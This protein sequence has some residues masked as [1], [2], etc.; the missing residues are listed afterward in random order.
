MLDKAEARLSKGDTTPSTL[1]EVRS[2]L[3]EMAFENYKKL[4]EFNPDDRQFRWEYGKIARV[5]GNLK[6]TVR[7]IETANE[8]IRLSLELQNWTPTNQRTA[9]ESDY[10]AETYRELA[11]NLITAGKLSD[12]KEAIIRSIEIV[13]NLRTSFPENVNYSRTLA[14]AWLEQVEIE[15]N[16]HQFEKASELAALAF[17]ELSKLAASE[18][19]H[20]LD[21]LMELFSRCHQVEILLRSSKHSEAST[22]AKETLSLVRKKL[23][24]QPN[25]Q[26]LPQSLVAILLIASEI[27]LMTDGNLVAV[28]AWTDE[29]VQTIAT[30]K[31]SMRSASL[32]QDEARAFCLQAEALRKQTKLT[33]AAVAIQSGRKLAENLLKNVDIPLH[34]YLMFQ[35]QWEESRLLEAEGKGVEANRRLSEAIISL[36]KASEQ[37]MDNIEYQKRLQEIAAIHPQAVSE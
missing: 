8:R 16:Q 17:S 31:K 30:L 18:K 35:V 24:D 4:Y 9:A 27:E 34:N 5:S 14:L 32:V 13:Q 19:P 6:R 15:T 23:T 36:K 25:D 28:I 21:L 33:E 22:A 10:L 12:A 1:I 37:S 20:P 11:T 3:T 26:F 2:D 29:A 7:Q